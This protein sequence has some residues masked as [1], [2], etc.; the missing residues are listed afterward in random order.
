[1]VVARG[2]ARSR[3]QAR[4]YAVVTARSCAL[5]RN[6]VLVCVICIHTGGK[7]YTEG[8]TMA[9]DVPTYSP[10]P[11]DHG[12]RSSAL[13]LAP[14][15]ER[16]SRPS[17]RPVHQSRLR[18]GPTPNRRRALELLASCPEGCMASLLQAR[19]FTVEQIV[20]LIRSGLA[21]AQIERVV[22]GRRTIE[23]ARIKITKEGRTAVRVLHA[24]RAAGGF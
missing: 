8:Q 1:V 14:A 10:L 20:A 15:L 5:E 12:R 9:T 13:D 17:P 2:G 16:L 7:G 19:G 3:A 11:S 22:A 6:I 18:R 24:A 23:V 4:V 21:R